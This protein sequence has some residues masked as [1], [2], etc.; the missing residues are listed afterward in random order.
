MRA[1]L[2]QSNDRRQKKIPK[3]KIYRKAQIAQLYFSW[4]ILTQLWWSQPILSWRLKRW[5]LLPHKNVSTIETIATTENGRYVYTELGMATWKYSN[6]CAY[7][8]G[9]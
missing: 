7:G 6:I 4:G 8:D 1:D 5:L 2:Y 9:V 3:Q